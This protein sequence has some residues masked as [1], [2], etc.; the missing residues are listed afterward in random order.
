MLANSATHER[1]NSFNG[2]LESNCQSNDLLFYV[3]LILL[4][5]EPFFS[6]SLL[7]GGGK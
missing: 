5:A 7:G 6:K 4:L 1:L 3:E 2:A